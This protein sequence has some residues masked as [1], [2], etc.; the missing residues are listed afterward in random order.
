MVTLHDLSGITNEIVSRLYV[1]GISNLDQLVR[2]GATSVGRMQ[3][4]D[5][6]SLDYSQIKRWVH[7]ADLL[8]LDGMTPR[9]SEKLLS[10][11]VLTIPKLAYKDSSDICKRLFDEFGVTESSELIQTLIRQAKTMPKLINH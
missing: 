10:I 2:H 11:E 4:A 1:A 5:K 6:A 8:R 3:I 7:Q 9:L